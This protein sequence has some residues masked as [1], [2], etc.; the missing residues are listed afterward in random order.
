[1]AGIAQLRSMVQ[2]Q[3]LSNNKISG[4][5]AK[6]LIKEAVDAGAT[7]QAQSDLL[8]L[9]EEFKDK[10][11]TAGLRDFDAR[12]ENTFHIST[13]A[14]GG[15]QSPLT[16][17]G[18][19]M[20]HLPTA[21]KLSE[22]KDPDVKKLLRSMD[23]NIDGRVD[24]KDKDRLGLSDG[25]W[26][27]FVFTALLAGKKVDEG[28]VFPQSL[29]GK[30]VVFSA[31]ADKDAGKKWAEKMGASVVSDVGPDVDFLV[32]GNDGMTGKDERAHA[33]NTLGHADI[34]IG[35]WARFV[36][37][38]EAAG[39]IDRDVSVDPAD[40]Q[41]QISAGVA[42]WYD[43]YV[44]DAYE[45]DIAN[46]DGA[47]ERAQLLAD[48]QA[49]LDDGFNLDAPDEHIVDSIEWQY[50][51]SGPYTDA[52]GSPVP[53]DDLEIMRLDMFPRFAG[54]G[55]SVHFVFDRRTGGMLEEFDVMD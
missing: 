15:G 13:G 25:Q 38:A 43:A 30:K 21:F 46:A 54:I 51:H 5:E 9:R 47:A 36:I 48:M 22:V 10:F 2:T 35:R 52:S 32:V 23:L 33:L 27:M 16:V 19:D 12:F 4:A 37:A 17:M 8:A 6:K 44:R 18:Q 20:S 55:L 31:V 24:H 1:M 28:D 42:A 29:A 49:D 45:D 50:E 26:R 40:A 11:T 53:F 34:T 41:A 3:F 7:T 14:A 39:A